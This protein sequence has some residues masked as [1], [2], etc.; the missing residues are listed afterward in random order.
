MTAVDYLLCVVAVAVAAGVGWHVGYRRGVRATRLNAAMA[1]LILNEAAGEQLA[2]AD[3]RAVNAEE[4]LHDLIRDLRPAGRG[5]ADNGAGYRSA[6]TQDSP[7]RP[8]VGSPQR[9]ASVV[10]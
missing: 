5:W 1:V 8:G 3:A 9:G 2:T 4:R 7:A 10:Q 6:T